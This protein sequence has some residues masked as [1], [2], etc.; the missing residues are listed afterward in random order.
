MRLQNRASRFEWFATTIDEMIEEVFDQEKL[1]E[2][3]PE[4]ED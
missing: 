3:E 2:A 1:A 4:Y